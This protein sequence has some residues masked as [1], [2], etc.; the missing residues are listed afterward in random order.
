MIAVQTVLIIAC[1][2]LHNYIRGEMV[3]DPVEA[4][5]DNEA[6][7]DDDTDNE[8]L[9]G[10]DNISSVEPSAL[11]TKKRDDLATAMWGYI[12]NRQV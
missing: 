8:P 2:L 4:E 7:I 3:V 9:L 1:F 11:W 10:G 12:N 5:L 6:D